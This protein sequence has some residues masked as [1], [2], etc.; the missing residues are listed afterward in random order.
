M[1]A[2]YLF[3]E[4]HFHAQNG[5]EEFPFTS[6]MSLH[7]RAIL[8]QLPFFLHNLN[9]LSEIQIIAYPEHD[10]DLDLHTT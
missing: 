10:G 8:F 9:K 2:F 5:F 4:F 7:F 3:S 6:R 1:I